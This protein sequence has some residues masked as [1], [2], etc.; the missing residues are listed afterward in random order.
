MK[1][2]PLIILSLLFSYGVNAVG[3][4]KPNSEKL[5]EDPTRVVTEL[6]ITY[7]DNYDTNN[8]S[9][10]LT[11]SVAFDPVRKI[12][13]RLNDDQS[14]WRV[15]G[16]W[17]FDFGIVNFNFGKNEFDNKNTQ[18]NYSVGTFVPLSY[19]GFEPLG[20][21]IFPTIGYNY[22][23]GE[24]VCD[25]NNPTG[26][27]L[28]NTPTFDDHYMMVPTSNQSGY[29]G[30]FALKPLSQKLTLMMAT[31]A[32][33]GTNDYDAWWLFGGISYKLA[34]KQTLSTFTYMI[35]NSYGQEERFGITYKYTFD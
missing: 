13:I 34:K 25:V 35:D 15:G 27:C 16:S 2:K 19:F 28:D 17:L 3:T 5:A 22:N 6:G 11:G 31:G 1:I 23:D 4:V 26:K 7:S 32:A 20:I 30:A 14:E 21:Q 29:V 12:N 9:W 24:E 18:T 33:K 10:S 8:D